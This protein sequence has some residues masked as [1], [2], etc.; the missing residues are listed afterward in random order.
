[1]R[2]IDLLEILDNSTHM[3]IIVEINLFNKTRKLD[4]CNGNKIVLKK[5]ERE[6]LESKVMNLS[7]TYNDSLM[8]SV[9]GDFK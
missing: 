8:I 5:V 9:K 4:I 7:K 6:I 1:M 3:Y 2:L